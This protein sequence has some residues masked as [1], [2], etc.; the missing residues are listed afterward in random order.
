MA[1]L[2]EN[3]E[4]F[5][6]WPKGQLEPAG[7]PA[8]EG[9]G[10]PGAGYGQ[11][12]RLVVPLSPSPMEKLIRDS[13]NAKN[14]DYG[15]STV[16]VAL[17]CAGCAPGLGGVGL[18]RFGQAIT[19]EEQ[20]VIDRTSKLMRALDATDQVIKKMEAAVKSPPWGMPTWGEN[21]LDA[22]RGAV[23]DSKTIRASVSERLTQY[24]SSDEW[25]KKGLD[26]LAGVAGLA[27]IIDAEIPNQGYWNA[28]KFVVVETTGTV[29]KGV[30][31]VG[32]RAIEAGDKLTSPWTM[33]A[34][35][36]GA[37]GIFIWAKS[38]GTLVRIE[39]KAEALPPQN[40]SLNPSGAR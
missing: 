24:T 23:K 29:V 21:S 33:I 18:G 8:Y 30:Q 15:I 14:G 9:T 1:R 16:G 17:G 4:L 7:N 38:G 19:K 3:E 12:R 37:L 40:T 10:F 11:R 39:R 34:V 2:L 5:E 13:V 27:A 35:G 22:W 25:L 6:P 31:E 32:N 36:L 20:A 28:L 26:R